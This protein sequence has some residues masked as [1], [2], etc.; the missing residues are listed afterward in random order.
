[1]KAGLDKET[2]REIQKRYGEVGCSQKGRRSHV[3]SI[4][5]SND[6]VVDFWSL[7]FQSVYALYLF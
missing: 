1:M 5:N 2:K 6:D 3:R 4:I 7:R